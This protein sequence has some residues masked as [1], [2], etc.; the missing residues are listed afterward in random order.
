MQDSAAGLD[1]CEHSPGDAG[2][3]EPILHR[4]GDAGK[5]D[6]GRTAGISQNRISHG[7]ASYSFW[8]LFSAQ[9]RRKTFPGDETV[10][11]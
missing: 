6:N 2:R 9:T 7:R 8:T 11:K 3:N 1:D 4:P 5:H 10:G